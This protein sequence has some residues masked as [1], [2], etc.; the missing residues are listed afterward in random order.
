MLH[1]ATLGFEHPVTGERV[2][3]SAPPPP[4]FSAV[5]EQLR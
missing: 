5:V 1:A 2:A 4:D 3:L